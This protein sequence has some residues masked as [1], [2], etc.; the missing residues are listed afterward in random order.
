MKEVVLWSPE[1]VTSWLTD[2]A[3][4][5]Y[6]EPLR[7]FTGRDLINLTEEDFKQSPLCRVSSDSGQRLL[8]MIEGLKMAHHMEAHK[9]GH[10]NGH[11]RAGEPARQNGLGAA[12]KLN[13]IPNG[14]KKEMIKIPMPEPERSQYPMEWGKTFLAFIYALFC[15]VFTTVTISV[16]HE[17]VPP[18][19][20]QP[21]LPDA[22]FDRFDRVQWAFS[23]CEI[24]GMILVGLWFVQWLLLKY[25]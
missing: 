15:F 6:C 12:L 14:F 9:N 4:P 18:K 17:R 3:V 19:E 20:V 22:F 25:K 2:N 10:A 16:V 11:V 21:P 23:I 5:E 7:S 1:E 13:G 24:N 8:T